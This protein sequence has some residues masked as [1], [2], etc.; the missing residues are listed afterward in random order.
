GALVLAALVGGVAWSDGLASSEAHLAPYGQL[1]ELESI[2]KTYAG[3]GPALMTEYQPYGVRHFLR[4]LDPEGASELRRRLVPL[5]DGRVLGK[6]ETAPIDAFAPDTV[7]V[8]RS[9]VLLR[10]T[11]GLPPTPFRLVRRGTY[12]DVWQRP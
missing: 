12:Y 4:R 3:D 5:A 10:A 11:G 7:R 8:Y 1:A 6:G 2:G 9:L